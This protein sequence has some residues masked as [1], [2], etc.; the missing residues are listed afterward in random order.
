MTK[1]NW[2][3]HIAAF[4]ASEQ[5]IAA[6]CT[7]AGIKL[8]TFRYHLY[9]KKKNPTETRRRVETFREFQVA[10]DLVITRDPLGNLTLS[11]FELSHLPEVIGAWCHALS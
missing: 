3:E 11:G 5:N 7:A 9:K 2:S 4:N 1:V 6:Y 10:T 8:D